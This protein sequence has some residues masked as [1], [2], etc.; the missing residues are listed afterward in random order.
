MQP[1]N[2]EITF[3]GLK[4]LYKEQ[5][6]KLETYEKCFKSFQRAEEAN[7]K[8]IADLYEE[9]R[10]LK[11]KLS[12][13]EKGLPIEKAKTDGTVYNWNDG[14][15]WRHVWYKSGGWTDGTLVKVYEGFSSR[16]EMTFVEPKIV[17]PLPSE[18]KE[19]S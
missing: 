18:T 1:Q 9:I 2:F 17:H 5:A 14:N 12:E 16:V 19:G 15:C 11:A 7:A 4:G 10:S 6:E 8:T 3:A 13:H